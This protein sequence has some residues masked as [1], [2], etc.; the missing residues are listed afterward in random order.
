MSFRLMFTPVL[1]AGA[2]LCVL[3]SHTAVA[4]VVTGKACYRYS[5][6]ESLTTAREIAL[7]M[8][9]RAALEGNSVFVESTSNVENMTL[10][11]DL[12]TNLTTG[13][14]KNLRVLEET[15]DFGLREVCRTVQAEVEPIEVKQQI[16]ARIRQF[17]DFNKDRTGLPR[18]E[19]LRVVN[20]WEDKQGRL[21][22]IAE[23]H[24][25][26]Q[27][28]QDYERRTGRTTQ[29][30]REVK[31]TLYDAEGYPAG[32]KRLAMNYTKVGDI[33]RH[34]FKLDGY[35]NYKITVD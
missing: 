21:N 7:S 11:N 25:Q 35:K 22:V 23:L 32:Q 18:G 30:K 28:A 8:A 14:L 34:V 9:K 4:E 29:R 12:I 31:V 2:L 19:F 10:K 27:P 3:A 6:N 20:A 16:T 1:K 33:N 17:T 13:Y 5:D 26:D 24:T 15:E